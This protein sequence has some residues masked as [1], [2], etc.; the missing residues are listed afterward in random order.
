MYYFH[1]NFEIN[2]GRF[3]IST[4]SGILWNKT[5]N[6]AFIGYSTAIGGGA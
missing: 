2:L 5:V 3:A 1:V 4:M 6:G